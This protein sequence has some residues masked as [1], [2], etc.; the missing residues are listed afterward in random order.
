MAMP[1]TVKLTCPLCKTVF[2]ARTMGSSYYIAGVE[3]DLRETGSIEDVRRFCVACCPCCGFGDYTWNFLAPDEL[4]SEERGA[5]AKVLGFDKKKPRRAGSR[6]Y[7]DFERFELAATCFRSRG[8]D[9]SALAELALGAYHVARD[10]GRRDLEPKLRADAAG[11]FERALEEED[12]PP[13]VR[14]RYAYLAG[15]LHR[16]AGDKEPALAAF[17]KAIIAAEEAGDTHVHQ[18]GAPVTDLGRLARRMQATLLYRDAP[19]ATL[20]ELTAEEDVELAS[21]ARRLLARR[22]DRA[23]VEA[24][25]TAW[26]KAPPADRSAMLQEL[27]VDPPAGLFELFVE[28]L[29]AAAPEDIRVAARALGALGDPRGAGPLLAALERGVLSTEAALV[30]A[31]KKLDAPGKEEALLELLD[32][33]EAQAAATGD[34]DEDAW[35]FTSDPTP[36]RNLLYGSGHPRGLELLIRDLKAIHENDLWDKV[37]SGGPVSAALVLDGAPK[38]ATLALR[39]LISASNPAAR[40]WACY[41][42]AELGDK[43]VMGE[44]REL[45]EDPDRCVRLQAAWAL[46]RL[47]DTSAEKV[48]LDELRALGDDDVPFALHFLVPFRSAAVKAFLLQLLDQG[49]ATA[50][51]VLPLLGRQESDDRVAAL[52]SQSL[53]DTNDDTRAGGVTGLAFHAP[54]QGGE[55]V[56]ERLRG[57]YDGEESDEVC[58]RIVFG[59]G[60]LARQGIEREETIQFLRERLGRGHARLRFA[61]ALTLLSLDDPSGI[62]IVRERAALFDESYERYDLVA[63]ALKVLAA[64][65]ARRAAQATPA[66]AR[67]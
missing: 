10:L 50:G 22:R 52:L 57:L 34:P 21:T 58:R 2:Q 28:A 43:K 33:W 65:D 66:A 60:Q 16:R 42:L 40:R 54:T 3:T 39:G 51:E 48:V 46:A 56:A 41:C 23:G 44:M 8:M 61:I 59:L 53:L 29:D 5:L 62:D 19:A 67:V 37:P 26:K 38:T 6:R 13:I 18:E 64:Y 49:K 27:A 35:R 55:G 9:P 11:L 4:T 20:L 30:E 7:R 15:E 32:R 24:V 17:E 45:L 1:D 25:R 36:I 12:L 47:G 31:L 63:P 14:L